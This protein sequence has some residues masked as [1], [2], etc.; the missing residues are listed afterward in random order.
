[1]KNI[2]RYF[3]LIIFSSLIIF[4]NQSCKKY[5]DGPL[6]S[7]SSRTSRVSNNWKVDNYKVNDV[8]LT[9]LAA[10]YKETFTSDNNYSFT[11]G[12]IGGTG[13]WAFENKDTEI[14]ITGTENMT[15]QTLY[16]LKLEQK[17]FWYYIMDGN[18][19]KEYH[20]IQQ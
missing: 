1:M 7:L 15:S 9:S 13:T 20:M 16:I 8:D 19:R 5:E 4:G 2:T 11:W 17:Q 12:I 18:D 10:D 14:R 3:A 6:I